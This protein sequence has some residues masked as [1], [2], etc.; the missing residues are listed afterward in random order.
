[1]GTAAVPLAGQKSVLPDFIHNINADY[2]AQVAHVFEVHNNIYDFVDNSAGD[3]GIEQVLASSYDDNVQ[4]DL[5]SEAKKDNSDTGLEEDNNNSKKIRIVAFYT[6]RGLDFPNQKSEDAFVQ[7]FKSVFSEEEMKSLGLGPNFQKCSKS[8]EQALRVLNNWFF[9]SKTIAKKNIM[10]RKNKQPQSA[11][12]CLTLIF[13][14]ADAIF[15]KGDIA[16]LQGDR[17]AI[18]NLRDWAQ[19]SWVGARNR[20]ILMTKNLADI[21]ESIRSEL[22]RAHP[23]R[24][25]NLQ[26]RAEWLSNFDKSIKYKVKLRNGEPLTIGNN[27]NV[28]GI[29]Y[30]PDFSLDMAAIQSAGMNRRQMKDAVMTAWRSGV[31]L[32]DSIVRT[33]KKE[34]LD[35][36]YNGLVDI[37]EGEHSFAEVGGHDHFKLYCKLKIVKPLKL[38]NRKLCSRGVLMTG[39]PGVGK[40]WIAW[41]LAKE[42]GLNFLIVDL[43]K[44]FAGLVGE[45]ESNI[46]KLIE[47]IEA[48]APCI[49]FIDEIDSVLSS[50]RVSQGDGGTSGRVFN[51]FMTWMSDPSRRGKVVVIAA[52]NRPDLLDSALIRQGRFDA[53]IPI[54]PPQRGDAVGKWSILA[55]LTKKHK[56]VFSKELIA[57]KDSPDKGLGMLLADTARIWTGAE[58]EAVIEEA[59]GL[60]YEAERMKSG[61]P[62]LTV[63]VEDFE[64]AMTNIPP[65]TGDLTLQIK[66]ALRFWNNKRFVPKEW[67]AEAVK[68]RAE[69]AAQREKDEMDEEAA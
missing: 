8:L 52:T 3:L 26:D 6:G 14:N 25:P 4:D 56:I 23:V 59:Y 45:T 24:K 53:I 5:Q 61:K 62:D 37:K 47:A 18:T 39:P 65:S 48:A 27:K 36:E 16:N 34:A 22:A 46:R 68:E 67:R 20:I 54:L 7:A 41:A 15:P 64:E 69:Y 57:T 19:D 55:A 60:A 35:T 17:A 42:T 33:R 12:L 44:V 10:Q 29:E 66:L 43:G 40:S 32:D 50:G 58:I 13:T 30:A 9:V 49:V 28:T 2:K 38:N 1:M 51:N 31:P 21:H 63:R 11:E